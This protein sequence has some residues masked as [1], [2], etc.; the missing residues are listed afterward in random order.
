MVLK[1]DPPSPQ[2]PE[3]VET[4]P[5]ERCSQ[6]APQDPS[7]HLPPASQTTAMCWEKETECC[8][9][10]SCR[11]YA[12][13][14]NIANCWGLSIR[15]QWMKTD[16]ANP[17]GP[18]NNFIFDYYTWDLHHPLATSVGGSLSPQHAT[19][20]M[21]RTERLNLTSHPKCYKKGIFGSS[22]C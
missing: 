20:V 19:P 1:T 3:Q 4:S 10:F 5:W 21:L 22:Q 18:L 13:S 11:Q 2:R 16:K 15:D 12:V 7:Q 9:L 8:L 6:P 17:P 14:D